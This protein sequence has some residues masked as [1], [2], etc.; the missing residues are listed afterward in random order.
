MRGCRR[1]REL[2]MSW[3]GMAA[4]EAYLE[5]VEKGQGKKFV[6]MGVM[7][8][9]TVPKGIDTKFIWGSALKDNEVGKV[10]VEESRTILPEALKAGRYLCAPEPVVVG[11]GLER[12]Q[13]AF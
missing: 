1:D 8:Q 5:I 3:N 13:K 6:A 9:G 10:V 7:L 12:I 11:K 2:R 4:G